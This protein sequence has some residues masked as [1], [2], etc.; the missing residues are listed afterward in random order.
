MPFA[1]LLTECINA[2]THATAIAGGVER[3]WCLG[4]LSV[5]VAQQDQMQPWLALAG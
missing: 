2:L 5:L 1:H 3:S 4:E